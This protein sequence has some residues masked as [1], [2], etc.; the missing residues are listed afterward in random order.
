[1]EISK[2]FQ[3][4]TFIIWIIIVPPGIY[5]AFTLFPSREIDWLNLSI[6]FA[7]LFVT[8]TVPLQLKN[9]TISMERWIT[10]TVFFQYGVFAE[11]VFTQMAMLIL[12]FGKKTDLPIMQRFFVNSMIFTP[13]SLASGALFHYAGG[14]IGS[15][16]FVNICLFG[17]L[18]AT[19]YTVINSA[20]MQLYLYFELGTFSL[21]E[22]FVIWDFISTMMLFP[23]SI[24]FYF[25]N[26]YFGNNAFILMGIPFLLV[27]IIARRYNQ[28][29]NMNDKLSSAGIIGHELADR[30]GYEDVI[31][32]FIEKLKDVVP[33]DNAYILDLRSGEYLITLMGSE[34]N[35]ITKNLKNFSYYPGKSKCDG[36]DIDVTRILS[37]KKEIR[38]LTNFEFTQGVECVMT[39]PIRRD[40]KTEGFLILTSKRKKIFEALDLKIVDVLTGYF[41]ISLVKA[42]LYEKTIKQSERCGLT[43]LHNFRYL[44]RK[45]EEDVIR[46]HTGEIDS[47]SAVIL[48]IDHFKSINDTYGHQSGN[49]L[50]CAL[51]TILKTYEDLD[52]TLA[53][54]GGEEFVF[55]LPNIDKDETVKLAE[56]IRSEVEST[57]FRVN[58]DLS[59][60]R[61]PLDVRMTVSIGI[62]N[63]PKD[64]ADAKELLRNADRA[65]Y[66]GGKQAGRNKVGVYGRDFVETL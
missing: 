48:D 63:V 43:K 28:S 27:L 38:S 21:K 34:N 46:Y 3:I 30:L 51:A 36:L 49:D 4:I 13:I 9:M 24:S 10:F 11:F 64:A 52:I 35:V 62:A 55:I 8:M 15:T 56:E 14:V 18:Y 44:D 66:I 53:R 19:S 22:K 16:D 1:M 50:L 42:R 60:G 45:L 33:Y 54:Y 5:L 20:L 57:I 37:T 65:L 7:L 58:P 26:E 47:L 17:L 40:Q 32:T 39:A 31:R 23:I 6:L 2:R 25:L 41:A 12:L 59:N 29:D 61:E